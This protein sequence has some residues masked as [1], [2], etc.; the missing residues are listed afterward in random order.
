MSLRALVSL[1]AGVITMAAVSACGEPVDSPNIV[2]T[3][4]AVA[5]AQVVGVERDTRGACPL[6]SAPDPA[7]GPT[8][9]V[10][11][12]AGVSTVPAD[13]KRI[14]VLST[15]ALDAACAVGLWERVAGAVT[16]DG[17]KPQPS[18][19]GTGIA[20]IPSVG[21]VGQADHGKIAALRPDLI[22]GGDPR[23][24]DA[25]RAIAPT[26]FT[27]R[28]S[29]WQSV[30]AATAAA[31]GRSTAATQALAEYRSF[32]RDTGKA[33]AAVQTQPSVVRFAPGSVR[34]QGSD[35]FASKVLA[36]VGVD[37]P[38]HQRGT[39]FDVDPDNPG[40][41][42]GD[43]IYVVLAG[44]AG[45]EYAEPILRTDVWK[46]LGAIKDQR[47][48]AVDDAIWNGGGIVAARAVVTDLKNTLNAVAS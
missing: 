3:T 23:D 44:K 8:R 27:G 17:P 1:A 15:Q 9:Q 35:T 34:V 47:F 21:G 42:E 7:A 46:E 25:L 16:V 29:S 10:Q 39:S 31:F 4:T 28:S 22:V 38:Y 24:Y 37:R 33:I 11:H 36:D 40:R 45:K 2:R 14:V 26:V 30:F 41:A 20:K 19:L 48:F 32:A 18:Y 6:P 43:L 12:A 5:G 13:P